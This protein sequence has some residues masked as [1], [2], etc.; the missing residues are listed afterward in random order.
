MQKF[1]KHFKMGEEDAI[2]YTKE[3][4]DFFD[5]DAMLKCKEIGDGNINY[6][7][8]VE[9]EKTGK[10]II[11]KHA[12][13]IIRTSENYLDP[14]HNRIEAEILQ[15]EGD[16]APGLVPKV[17]FY[18]PV[19]LCVVMEDLR[20]YDNMRYALNEHKMFPT[21]ADDISTFMANTLIRTN[22]SVISPL[23]KK[24]MQKSYINPSLCEISER[25]VYA[26]PYTDF[27][28]RNTPNPDN[29]EFL[30]R[31]LYDDLPLRLEVAKMNE[32]FKSKAQ[33]LIHGDLHTGSIFVKPGKTMV[34]DPEFAFYG[35]AGYD[36]GNVIANLVFAYAN[37]EVTI[38][39]AAKREE[40][41]NYILNTI[42][43]IV[44]MFKEKSFK[45]L[46][47][48]TTD[49]LAKTPGFAEYLIDDILIDTAGVAGLEI[50][51][52][53]IGMAK[54][55]DITIIEEPKKRILAEKILVLCAKE[56]IMNRVDRFKSGEEYKIAIKSIRDDLLK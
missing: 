41:S 24:E 6:V 33:S 26:D 4:L 52:R 8:R 27:G 42:S 20:D 15:I 23:K 32:I 5:K 40:F 9:D 28:G 36:V 2:L 13:T 17:Y 7:F 3:K 56:F 1:D 51:R 44:D 34:L 38:E 10:S 19:M 25:L 39:D 30:E 54:V 45:I 11:I 18:D 46:A 48:E 31:E 12:D 53:V 35:P 14:D 22:D 55:R 29:K 50:N 43:E 37:G 21:F 16:L 47:L 49:V